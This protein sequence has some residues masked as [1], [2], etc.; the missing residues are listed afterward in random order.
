MTQYFDNIIEK[1]SEEDK[2][3]IE[4]VAYEEAIGTLETLYARE[5]EAHIAWE[6][7]QRKQEE[8]EKNEE[9]AQRRW[10]EENPEC[11]ELEEAVLAGDLDRVKSVIA[12]GKNLSSK[13]ISIILMYAIS[14]GYLDIVKVLINAGANTKVKDADNKTTLIYAAYYGYT[15]I[16]KVLINARVNLNA[17]DKF[18]KTALI[19]AV[20]RCHTDTV[21]VLI[22]AGADIS[23]KDASNETAL[24]YAASSG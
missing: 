11:F 1:Y 20:H 24:I 19:C 17:K 7:A 22:N 9:E 3:A 14:Y 8:D 23:V 12:I 5:L 15:D 13:F 18:N 16:V 21:K 10:R 2:K 4:A 6:E